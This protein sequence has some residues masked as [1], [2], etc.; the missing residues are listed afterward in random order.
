MTRFYSLEPADA[1]F[2]ESGP[3]VFTYQKRFAATPSQVWEQL[4][5]DA[6]ISAW[7]PATKAVIWTSPRPFGVG[8]TRDVVAPGGA[9][10]R[11]RFFRWEDGKRKSFAV[12]EST[13]PMFK[14]FAEDYIVEPDGNDTLFTWTLAIEP[15]SAL[16]LPF[17]VLAPVIKAAFGRIPSDGQRYWA[18]HFKRD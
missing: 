5:S 17:R 2:F 9:T 10:M 13:L 1:D 12:Y 18:K 15:R 6:S 7:G 3:H 8:T 4:T 14:R 11:E 16:A